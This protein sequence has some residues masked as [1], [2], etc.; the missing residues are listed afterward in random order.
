MRDVTSILFGS[1][2]SEVLVMIY[3]QLPPK[4][5]IIRLYSPR[6]SELLSEFLVQPPLVTALS[7]LYFLFFNLCLAYSVNDSRFDDRYFS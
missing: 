6:S 5:D 4:S 7:I 2:K 1:I 3:M